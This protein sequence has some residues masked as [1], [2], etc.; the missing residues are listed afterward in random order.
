MGIISTQGLA[1]ARRKKA[2]A[3][4]D[5]FWS[6][7][8]KYYYRITWLDKPKDSCNP[9]TVWCYKDEL[10]QL[11]DWF[12]KEKE[13]HGKMEAKGIHSKKSPKDYLRIGKTK[14]R[15]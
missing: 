8:N 1:N 14:T 11:Q 13:T 3:A 9:L 7:D 15:K 12:T 10:G 2:A 4:S 6:T 5:K